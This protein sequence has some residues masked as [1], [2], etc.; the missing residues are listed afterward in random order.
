MTKRTEIN[1]TRNPPIKLLDHDKKNPTCMC[2][3]ENPMQSAAILQIKILN[4][5]KVCNCW[6]L[7]KY[8]D[9]RSLV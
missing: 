8:I 6:V 9:K 2:Q 5:Y 1:F 3:Y 4:H 7:I